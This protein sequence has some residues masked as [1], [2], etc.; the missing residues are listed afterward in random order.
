MSINTAFVEITN[1]C[2]QNCIYCYNG[3][4]MGKTFLPLKDMVYIAREGKNAGLRNLIITGGEPTI[5]PNL[6]EFIRVLS[7]QGINYGITTNGTNLSDKIV[8]QLAQDNASV[9]ISLDTT[10]ANTYQQIRKT[11]SANKVLHNIKRLLGA[12]ISLDIGI[13][14]NKLNTPTIEK[15]INELLELGVS[16]IHVKE[17]QFIGNGGMNQ[18]EI[19]L[20][21]L[22]DVLATLYNLEKKLYPALSIDLIE[23]FLIRLCCSGCNDA[24]CN[25]M[26]GQAIQIDILGNVYHCKNISQAIP[27]VGNIH[28]YTL[29]YLLTKSQNFKVSYTELEKCEDCEFG[30]ICRGGCRTQAFLQTGNIYSKGARCKEYYKFISLLQK[31]QKEGILDKLLFNIKLSHSFNQMNG[32]TK[33]I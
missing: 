25:C 29:T 7:E 31:E 33:Y 30:Y 24:Y 2:N 4:N 1:A 12:N 27:S 15:T 16:T 18:K 10:D 20:D 9:Q 28:E 3:E 8:T 22:Y 32:F 19:E 5:H 14:L 21:N 11:N 17:V 13:V 6:Y 26:S 23:D